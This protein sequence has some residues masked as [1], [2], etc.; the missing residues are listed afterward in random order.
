MESQPMEGT[1]LRW[2]AAFE[3]SLVAEENA[4]KHTVRNYVSDLRQLHG[5]LVEHRLGLDDSGREVVPERI[6]QRALR[7]FLSELLRR[8]RKSSV[9]RKLSSSKGFF[10]FLLRRNVIAGDPSAGLVTPKKEQQLPVHLTVDD[11]FRLLDAPPK[12]TPA[13]LRDRAILEVI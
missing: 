4:S 11:M 12:D 1:L 7:A 2:I 6:D 9:G 8:N 10:R 13:G 5:F 3:R